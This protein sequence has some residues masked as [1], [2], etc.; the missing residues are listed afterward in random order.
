MT[1]L[2]SWVSVAKK[3]GEQHQRQQWSHWKVQFEIF[4]IS[5]LPCELS[6]TCMLKRPGHNH[7]QIMCNISSV[8]HLEHVC[9]VVWK[10]SSAINLNFILLA[11]TIIRWRWLQSS[12][13]QNIILKPVPVNTN[14]IFAIWNAM[15][16]F[17][18]IQMTQHMKMF[19]ALIPSTWQTSCSHIIGLVFD[20]GLINWSE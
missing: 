2:R 14:T 1:F 4:A 19:I 16:I 20:A 13:R 9:Q 5:S 3:A 18:Q 15:L 11:E 17:F 7:M 6:P 8:Y 12:L 10:D